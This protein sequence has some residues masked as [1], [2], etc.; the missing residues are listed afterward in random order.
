MRKAEISWILGGGPS[1]APGVLTL[2]F[3]EGPDPQRIPQ[4]VVTDLHPPVVFLLLGC[5][6]LSPGTESAHGAAG[7]GG[8][9]GQGRAG[10][11]RGGGG[12][13]GGEPRR[14]AAALHRPPG[15][16]RRPSG[17]DAPPGGTSG[18]RWEGHRYPSPRSASAWPGA[19]AHLRAGGGFL[20]CRG[21]PEP[22]GSFPLAKSTQTVGSPSYYSGLVGAPLPTPRGKIGLLG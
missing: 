9:G 19:P 6:H 14:R 17:A 20:D 1:L 18:G 21:G 2:H 7:G 5:R 10:G 22:L 13:A 12:D 8:G 15:P 3:A 4:D 16:S 11:G